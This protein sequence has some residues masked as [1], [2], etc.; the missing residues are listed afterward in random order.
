MSAVATLARVV[1]RAK[2]TRA[3]ESDNIDS[4]TSRL[5]R[6]IANRIPPKIG[7]AYTPIN[8]I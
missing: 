4:P 3:G 2:T 7:A 5:E 6:L 1:C 8:Q